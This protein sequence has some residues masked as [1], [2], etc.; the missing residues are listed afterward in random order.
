MQPF[1]DAALIADPPVEYHLDG[2]PRVATG[3]VRITVRPGALS[4][5]VPAPALVS[6]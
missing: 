5:M 4:V 2:E 1:T 6:G 3:P